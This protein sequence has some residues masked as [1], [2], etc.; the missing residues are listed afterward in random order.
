[1]LTR[2]LAR[3]LPLLVVLAL[4][5]LQ[6][7]AWAGEAPPL[8]LGG[9]SSC[10]AATGV[11]GELVTLG[12]RDEAQLMQAAV[13]G[14]TWRGVFLVLGLTSLAASLAASRLRDPGFGRWDT[15]TIRA[16]PGSRR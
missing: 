1:M 11:P 2:V 12:E 16:W 7:R 4:L 5:V 3:R 10:L 15:D 13:A 9:G 8:R 14:F 6:S